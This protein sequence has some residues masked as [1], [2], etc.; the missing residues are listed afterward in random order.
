MPVKS[1]P[2]PPATPPEKPA[3]NKADRF[4]PE[5]PNIPGISPGASLPR[6]GASRGTDIQPLLQIGGIAMVVALLGGAIYWFAMSRHRGA[7]GSSSGDAD[8]T[9]QA[10]PAPPVADSLAP[11]QEGPTVAGTVEELSKPWSAKKFVFSDPVTRDKTDAMV[12]RLPGGELWAFS[13]KGTLGNC[14]LEFVTDAGSLASQYG[15]RANH[16][17]VVSPCDRT[18]Y[19]PMKVGD[20]G[21]NVFV[22]GEIVHGSALRPPISIDVK[23]SGNSIVADR[24]E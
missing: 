13:R 16:P 22:R 3:E 9:E 6:P 19:D 11:A 1:P 12:I 2:T 10:A 20:I 17:M 4:R 5:M 18:V 14:E 21:G 15:Y 24:I 23:V 7:A 8:S